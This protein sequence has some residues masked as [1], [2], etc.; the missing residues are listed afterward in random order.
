MAD[1]TDVEDAIV[2]IVAQAVYPSGI[3]QPSALPNGAAA[4]VARGWPLP[5]CLDDDLAAGNTQITVYPLGGTSS[6]TYQLLDHT[7]VITP[8]AVTTTV[9]VNDNVI[10]VSGTL[11]DGEYLTLILDD[12]AICSQG[13][14]TVADMLSALAA[15]AQSKGYTA[16]A[17]SNTLTVNF[18]HKMVVRQGGRGV[19]G[20]VIHRQK[21]S[22]MV[23]VWAPSDAIR[24]AAAILADVALKEH[25]KIT[26]PDTSQCIL[27]Y[28]RTQSTDQQEK[29]MIY[30]RDL[31]Y[32]AEYATV[33]Q[34]PAYEITS[35][36]VS[37]QNLA[38]NNSV[39][40]IAII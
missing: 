24:T 5:K 19:Q 40:T 29:A 30:R 35:T 23:C 2:N 13:G 18:G 17:T 15:E 26:M 10:T 28:Q 11:S 7:Y 8:P 12:A 14:A 6:T 31:I 37:I 21:T 27:R 9:V 3:G 25:I 34:F 20:R 39:N 36:Q 16:S 38:D 32:E 1:L 4:S 22:I 33:E